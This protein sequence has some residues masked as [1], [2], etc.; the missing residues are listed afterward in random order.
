MKEDTMLAAVRENYGEPKTVAL[1]DVDRPTVGDQEVLVE[2]RAAGLDPGVWHIVTGLPYLVRLAGYGLRKPKNKL[3][4]S[5]V[6][7][8]VEAVGRN[9]TRFQPDGHV[10][11]GATARSPSTPAR[12]RTGWHP[13]RAR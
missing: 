5:D 7:G 12:M 8:R 6:A 10:S 3:V 13:S 11:A 9:V 1:R 2:V 4:G